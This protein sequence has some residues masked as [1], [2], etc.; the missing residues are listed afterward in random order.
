MKQPWMRRAQ[1]GWT[2]V[3]TL[4]EGCGAAGGR[5]GDGYTAGW[6][7]DDTGAEPVGCTCSKDYVRWTAVYGGRGRSAVAGRAGGRN[8]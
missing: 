6:A 8:E 3:N 2:T 7:V 1:P 5:D 4:R